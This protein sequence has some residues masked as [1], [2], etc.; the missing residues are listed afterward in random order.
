MVVLALTAM[1]VTGCSVSVSQRQPTYVADLIRQL[2]PVGIT[3]Q[4]KRSVVGPDPPATLVPFQVTQRDYPET[5]VKQ[6]I[7]VPEGIDIQCMNGT[8]WALGVYNRKSGGILNGHSLYRVENGTM[9]KVADVGRSNAFGLNEYPPSGDQAFALSDQYCVWG[10]TMKSPDGRKTIA[11]WAYDLITGKSLQWGDS[12]GLPRLPS[13]DKDPSQQVLDSISTILLGDDG[14]AFAVITTRGWSGSHLDVLLQCKLPT[15]QA[16]VVATVQDAYWRPIIQERSSLWIQQGKK[17]GLTPQGNM[18]GSISLIRMDLASGTPETFITDSPLLGCNTDGKRI[19]LI[20][21]GSTTSMLDRPWESPT[22]SP[23]ADLW[24]FSPSEHTLRVVARVPW[25]EEI[26]RLGSIA[27]LTSGIMYGIQGPQ[28][29]FFSFR[30]SK[31]YNVDN[32]V[33]SAFKGATRFGIYEYGLDYFGEKH[34]PS[35]PKNITML[36]ILEP[37]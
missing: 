16:H 27:L 2:Q 28:H 29:L 24:L 35:E 13:S 32:I 11:L 34:E 4:W 19:L 1:L 12:E 21:E 3:V 23:Y 6:E 33:V 37:N 25:K 20:H 8:G 30:E 17:T 22:D 26:G 5:W 36:Q 15:E 14:T 9:R 18:A 31:F 10:S 7:A